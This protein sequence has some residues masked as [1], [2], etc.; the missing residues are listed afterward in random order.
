MSHSSDVKT[1]D[2]IFGLPLLTNAIPTNDVNAAGTG[3][4]NVS[5]VN[6]LSDMFTGVVALQLLNPSAHFKARSFSFG[7][8]GQAGQNVRILAS[9]NLLIWTP[10]WTNFL[11]TA[12]L[13]F[14]DLQ[15]G[16]FPQRFYRAVSP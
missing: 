6:D 3:C 16:S 14:T 10:I 2:E 12:P 7:L 8:T 15:S 1:M 13:T 9:S 11:G 5:T 4:N